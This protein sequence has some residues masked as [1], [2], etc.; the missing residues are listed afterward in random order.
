M[1]PCLALVLVTV[2][3]VVYGV[4]VMVGAVLPV[5]VTVVALSGYHSAFGSVKTSYYHAPEV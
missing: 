3:M 4:L 5:I 1:F 2:T